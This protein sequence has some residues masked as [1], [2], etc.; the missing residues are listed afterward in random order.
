ARTPESAASSSLTSAFEAC[1]RRGGSPTEVRA[2]SPFF[3]AEA[4]LNAVV[5][6]VCK[7]MARGGKRQVRFAVPVLRDEASAMLRLAAPKSLLR[8]AYKY[9]AK[10]DVELLPT[11]DGN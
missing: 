6:T 9:G 1:R 2:A 10:A 5:A 4:E 11:K 3:D 7:A 8:T